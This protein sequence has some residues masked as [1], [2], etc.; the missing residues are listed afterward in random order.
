MREDENINKSL[1][2]RFNNACKAWIS[3]STLTGKLKSIFAVKKKYRYKY[4]QFHYHALWV[5][6]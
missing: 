3:T 1:L 6:I 4:N 5:M 2:W